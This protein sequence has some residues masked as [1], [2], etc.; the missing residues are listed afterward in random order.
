MIHVSALLGE[1]L[2]V[3]I[4]TAAIMAADQGDVSDYEGNCDHHL[5][6]WTATA[7]REGCLEDHLDEQI[8]CVLASGVA[9]GGSREG[10][11]EGA[12]HVLRLHSQ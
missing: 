2:Y 10:E 1:Y 7:G 4:Y 8:G 11:S 12:V 5:V 3:A 6:P 9:A